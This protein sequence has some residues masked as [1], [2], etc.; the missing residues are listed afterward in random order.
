MRRLSFAALASLILVSASSAS[1]GSIRVT[2]EGRGIIRGDLGPA[3]G[4]AVATATA[5]LDRFG[6][7]LG[8]GDASFAI[9]SVRHSII[10]THVRGR[11]VR[12]GVPVEGTSA[13]VHVVDGTIVQVEARASRLAGQPGWDLIGAEGART[14]ALHRLGVT[15]PTV[16]PVTERLLV[17]AGDRLTD[18]WRVSVFSISPAVAAQVDIAAADGRV[19]AVADNTV[20]ADGTA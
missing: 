10:G 8:A 15:A 6:D 16:P 11:E 14:I 5:A 12:G 7:R 1:T 17:R 3:A 19:L 4:G 9:D 20:R 13:A 2:S 18:A